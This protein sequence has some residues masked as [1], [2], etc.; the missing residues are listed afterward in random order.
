MSARTRVLVL[1]AALVALSASGSAFAAAPTNLHPFLLRAD[2]SR[3]TEF[4]RDPAFAW[5][6][7]R[8]A[9]RYEF[10]LSTS[11]S[12]R[13]N[14]IVYADTS[15]TTPVAAPALT[16]PWISGTPHALY[17]RVRAI[18]PNSATDWSTPYGF[19]MEAAS[20][21]APLPSQPG[22]LRWT[23]VDGA[24]GYQV[25]FVDIPKTIDVKTNVADERE[26]YSFHQSGAWLEQRALARTRDAQHPERPPQRSPSRQLRRVEP[27][28]QLSQPAVL[29]WPT[30]P[31]DDRVRCGLER[32]GFRA[33]AQADARVRLR[34]QRL[35]RLHR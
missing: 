29:A 28:L 17:A 30:P 6:P 23:P 14:G 1:L 24:V 7:V 35:L 25:W 34:R 5:N 3:E 11:S 12:F 15:L 2:E 33:G 21:P 16:L 8:S 4:S 27:R 20:I 18:L 10:Q 31:A 9:V 32:D 22:L 26:F 19:D 13:E